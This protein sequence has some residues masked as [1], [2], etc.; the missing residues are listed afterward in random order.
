MKRK[1][2]RILEKNDVGGFRV[3]EHGRKRKRKNVKGGVP[4]M[5]K[6]EK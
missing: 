1:K 5:R 4:R 3:E 2:D 6:K